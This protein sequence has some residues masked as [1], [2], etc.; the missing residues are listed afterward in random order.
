MTRSPDKKMVA[1]VLIRA[2]VLAIVLLVGLWIGY[3]CLRLIIAIGGAIATAWHVELCIPLVMLVAGVS[4]CW[5]AGHLLG[6][7]GRTHAAPDQRDELSA[8]S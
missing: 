6:E 5:L 4:M 1:L 7:D 3:W 8:R 2:V